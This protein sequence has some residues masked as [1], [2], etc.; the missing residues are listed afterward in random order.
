MTDDIQIDS[1]VTI[2]GAEYVR[3]TSDIERLRAALEFYAEKEN[4]SE[5]LVPISCGCCSDYEDAK[6]YTD[7]GHIARAAL[8]GEQ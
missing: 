8:G 2:T 3:L 4:Y 7:E 1:M 5:Q 6:I